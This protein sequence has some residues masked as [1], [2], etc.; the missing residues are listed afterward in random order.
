M[1]STPI[2]RGCASHVPGTWSQCLG[3]RHSAWVMD[4][5]SSLDTYWDPMASGAIGIGPESIFHQWN[6]HSF[7]ATRIFYKTDPLETKKWKM[8][9]LQLV[10]R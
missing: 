7:I 1:A 9:L 6:M 10:S 5:V 2:D 3:H 4:T 8:L